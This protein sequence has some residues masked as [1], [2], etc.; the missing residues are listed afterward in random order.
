MDSPFIII[1]L[2]CNLEVE[3]SKKQAEL[4]KKAM[5]ELL[6]ERDILNKVGSLQ[7]HWRMSAFL[8]PCSI[9]IQQVVWGKGN[10]GANKN[11]LE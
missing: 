7:Q 8:L 4:D 5:D 11:G 3:S 2:P 9:C 1:F 10:P 6:R